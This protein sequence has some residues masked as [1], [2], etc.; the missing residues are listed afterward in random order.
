M[1]KVC[2]WNHQ[3]LLG[4]FVGGFVASCDS[5]FCCCNMSKSALGRVE[6]VLRGEGRVI[7][8]ARPKLRIVFASRF[9]EQSYDTLPTTCPLLSVSVH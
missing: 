8:S 7:R 1:L 6:I 9:Q 5:R 3:A 2:E 4:R